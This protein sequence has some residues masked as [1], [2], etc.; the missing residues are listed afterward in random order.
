MDRTDGLATLASFDDV[1]KKEASP[2]SI[3][4][5]R[6]NNSDSNLKVMTQTSDWKCHL[7]FYINFSRNA[8][9]T[10]C[11]TLKKASSTTMKEFE[12]RHEIKYLETSTNPAKEEGQEMDIS[13]LTAE[14]GELVDTTLESFQTAKEYHQQSG[15]TTF[16]TFQTAKEYH[17][18]SADE[19][20]KFVDNSLLSIDASEAS[21]DSSFRSTT[22]KLSHENDELSCDSRLMESPTKH[23]NSSVNTAEDSLNSI[24][25]AQSN[26]EED[27]PPILFTRS[28]DISV[29]ENYSYATFS[30]LNTSSIGIMPE[31]NTSILNTSSI[32]IMPET[33]ASILDTS[34]IVIMP[35]TYNTSMDQDHSLSLDQEFERELSLVELKLSVQTVDLEDQNSQNLVYENEDNAATK[36]RWII[37]LTSLV[38]VLAVVF[39]SVFST[40]QQGR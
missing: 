31:T 40:R 11:G 7:C 12:I 8:V 38:G 30:K 39:L 15:D 13:F 3:V 19:L 17:Q 25:R 28:E 33:D 36:K 1:K 20:S 23:L 6:R 22:Q 26:D 34:S 21:R 9:C 14:E 5:L 37:R 4:E 2:R 24:L 32:G 18:Q 27:H 29:E 16:E 10:M 35:E